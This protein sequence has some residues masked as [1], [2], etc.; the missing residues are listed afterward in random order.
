[1]LFI[2]FLRLWVMTWTRWQFIFRGSKLV[3]DYYADILDTYSDK[4]I[5]R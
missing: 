5:R 1:M 2:S 4:I 3:G